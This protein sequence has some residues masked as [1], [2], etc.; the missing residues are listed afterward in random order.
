M[1]DAPSAVR[2]AGLDAAWH[3]VAAMPPSPAQRLALGVLE[4]VAVWLSEQRT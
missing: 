2:E 3:E 1:S 4:H